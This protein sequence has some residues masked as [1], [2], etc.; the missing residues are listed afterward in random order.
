MT[1]MTSAE[2]EHLVKLAAGPSPL[3]CLGSLFREAAPRFAQTIREAWAVIDSAAESYAGICRTLEASGKENERLRA[4]L[5]HI[6]TVDPSEPTRA[7]A[8]DALDRKY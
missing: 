8:R 2:L 6:S 7:Y 5:T 3:D 4:S 1:N